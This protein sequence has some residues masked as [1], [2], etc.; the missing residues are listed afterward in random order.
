[1]FPLV[2]RKRSSLR[3]D[4]RSGV[5]KK[6]ET[7]L[8]A[9]SMVPS[10]A[11]KLSS[12]WRKWRKSSLSKS[13]PL[14]SSNAVC[15]PSSA[16]QKARFRIL[17]RYKMRKVNKNDYVASL[18]SRRWLPNCKTSVAA[19]QNFFKFEFFNFSILPKLY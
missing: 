17:S 12:S 7:V 10:C 16:A 13:S 19:F 11:H 18:K 2:R 1:M 14:A 8:P 5:K 6:P 3:I 4:R 9:P 15:V